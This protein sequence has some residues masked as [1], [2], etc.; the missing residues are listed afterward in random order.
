MSDDTQRIKERLSI[1]EIVGQYVALKQAGA[2][3][4]GLC[5]FHSEKTPSFTVSS[6]RQTYHCFGCGAHGDIFTFVQEMEGLDFRAAL[7]TLADKAGVEL[8]HAPADTNRDEKERLKAVCEAA[9]AFYVQE[10]TE[11]TDALDYLKE[12]GVHTKTITA[13]R[14]G[15]APDSW[16]AARVHLTS[17]GFSESDIEAAGLIKQGERGAYDRFRSRIMFPIFDSGGRVVA[18]SG[19]IFGKEDDGVGKYINSPETALYHKSKI[20]YGYDRARQSIRRLDCAI[21]VEGQMDIVLTHQAGYTNTVALS[22]TALTRE[23]LT[24]LE[25]MSK[26]VVIALDADGAGIKSAAA[27]ARALLRAGF[28]VKVA[29]LP[30][31]RDPADILAAG[32]GAVWKECV[33]EAKHIIEFLLGVY[34]ARAKDERA[35]ALAV[36][37]ELLAYIHDITSE[38]DKTHFI[39]KI[40]AALSVSEE[41]VRAQLTRAPVALEEAPPAPQSAPQEASLLATHDELVR[42]YLW[43]RELAQPALDTEKLQKELLALMGEDALAASVASAAADG[44]APFRFEDAYRSDEH[45]RDVCADLLN[46]L[47]KQQ[48]TEQLEAVSQRLRRAEGV[49]DAAAIAAHQQESQELIRALAEL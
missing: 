20:L 35:F 29:A 41:A 14:I 3:L 31:G 44:I 30:E 42:L 34:R 5:P 26:N 39:R 23:Q 6:A 10:L 19:R 1:E 38:I 40:A 17:L 22:G 28:D 2:N 47:K 37:R 27:S 13:F 32:D 25:R 18:F 21:L 15:F 4:K 7:T 12:R 36:E 8:T 9:A 48:L 24:L 33:R 16:D 43:Q 45:I 49:G 46:R 11:R